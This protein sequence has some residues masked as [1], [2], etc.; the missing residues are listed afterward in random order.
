MSRPR[1]S[2]TVRR[3]VA[4]RAFFRCEYCQ[5]PESFSPGPFCVEHIIPT[6]EGGSPGIENLAFSCSGCNGHKSDKLAAL[7]SISG[8]VVALFNPRKS[9]WQD[10]FCWSDDGVTVLGITPTGRATIEAL[11]FNRPTV[12]AL[13]RL[14]VAAGEHPPS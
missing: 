3:A 9:R 11:R 12:K 14:L 10:H 13:R 6:A 2:V 8:E 4:A 1:V 5:C 7:D